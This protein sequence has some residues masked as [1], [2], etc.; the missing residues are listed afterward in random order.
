MSFRISTLLC[1]AIIN[2]IYC[3]FTPGLFYNKFKDNL[4]FLEKKLKDKFHNYEI[5]WETYIKKGFI[6]IC[7]ILPNIFVSYSLIFVTLIICAIYHYINQPFLDKHKV[8]NKM[9]SLFY[10]LN[11]L[12]TSLQLV[13]LIGGFQ[14]LILSI[15]LGLIYI[16]S[17]LIIGFQ[18]LL[19]V[20]KKIN[21]WEQEKKDKK[22]NIEIV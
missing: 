21:I 5:I 16:I 12:Y 15:L 11:I 7:L 13:F 20:I 19:I 22:I 17:F 18:L 10:L 9:V 1:F 2:A 4:D 6:S 3:F 8:E 14:V